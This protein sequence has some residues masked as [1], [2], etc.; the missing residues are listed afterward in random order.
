MLESCTVTR[1]WLKGCVILFS[2]NGVPTFLK[3]FVSEFA[4]VDHFLLTGEAS[5]L[6]DLKTSCLNRLLCCFSPCICCPPCPE[7]CSTR[8]EFF[9]FCKF[10]RR[11]FSGPVSRWIDVSSSGLNT[12]N[13]NL[14]TL[15][16]YFFP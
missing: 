12:T 15:I 10:I 5:I 13:L 16:L 7:P 6:P 11:T 2:C 8:C 4:A 1:T 14:F 3:L 9:E